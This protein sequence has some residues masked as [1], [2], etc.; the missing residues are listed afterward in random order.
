MNDVADLSI[1][2]H[3]SL[4]LVSPVS[5][6]GRAWLE[7]H[8]PEDDDHIYF[9]DALVVEPRYAADLAEGATADRLMVS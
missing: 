6:E 1:A 8:C 4:V 5:D 3:G 2:N 7:E 9:G